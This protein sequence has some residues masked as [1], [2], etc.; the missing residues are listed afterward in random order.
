MITIL[1]VPVPVPTPAPVPP[2]AEVPESSTTPAVVT[3]PVVQTTTINV[4]VA[5]T[6]VTI[7]DNLLSS[8]IVVD[9]STFNVLEGMQYY[10]T[11]SDNSLFT[12]TWGDKYLDET[13]YE[14][15]ATILNT[16][17][18][19]VVGIWVLST[20]TLTSDQTITDCTDLLQYIKSKPTYVSHKK[21]LA[22]KYNH[23]GA[24][25]STNGSIAT[26]EAQVDYLT[27]ILNDLISTNPDLLAKYGADLQ[28][29]IPV[30][31]VGDGKTP[32]VSHIVS[33]KQKIRDL[34][35][36]YFNE[37]AAI[38]NGNN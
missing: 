36:A 7:T 3:A 18:E 17:D 22:S 24:K 33:D 9:T 28:T 10:R 5:N 21:L 25:L 12:L 37:R 34:Q 20:D 38:L 8:P 23:F 19:V 26:L 35:T 29:L 4:T 1:K 15:I 2:P 30:A 13:Q 32:L 14:L 27:K 6:T 31:N 11:I 16:S